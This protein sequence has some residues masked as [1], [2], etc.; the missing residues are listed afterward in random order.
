M[1][2]Y[3]EMGH[4]WKFVLQR[5]WHNKVIFQHSVIVLLLLMEADGIKEGI[6]EDMTSKNIGIQ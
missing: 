6:I 1:T 3:K 4:N 5:K 2:Y